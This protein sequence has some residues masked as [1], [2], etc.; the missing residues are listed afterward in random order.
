MT[1]STFKKAV[2]PDRPGCKTLNAI[3]L[4]PCERGVPLYPLRYG[5][6]NQPINA[7][8][9]PTLGVEG[10]PEL[11][12]GKEYGLRVLRPG[13]YVYLFYFRDGRMLTR[14]YQ[15]T[16]DVRF[17]PLWWS[18]ADY[19]D[20]APGRHVPP[21]IAGS[22]LYLLAPETSVAQTVYVLMS[23]TIL[24]HATLWKIEQDTNGL[25]RHLATEVKPEG[26]PEQKNA[27]DAVLLGSSTSELLSPGLS[28]RPRHF[29]WS[30]VV[31][32]E[33]MASTD[34]IFNAM[35][36][37]LLP[38]KDIKPLAVVLNDFL[39]MASELNQICAVDV[40][41]RDR[42]LASNKHRL[43]SAALVTS[44]FKHAEKSYNEGGKKQEIYEALE[45]QRKLVDLSGARGFTAIYEKELKV[46][47]EA[48]NRTGVDAAVWARLMNKSGLVGKA[49][50]L[51]DLSCAHN[52]SDFE[53]A[54][55]NCLAVS[56]Y[57]EAGLAAL[58]EQIEANPE[59][60]PLWRALSAGS[61][62]LMSRLNNPLTIAKRVYDLVD[63]V[64]D[65]RPGTV[66]TDLLTRLLWPTLS[67]APPH[68]SDVYVRRLRHVAEMRFG[69]VLGRRD[70]PLEQYKKWALELQ[71]YTE[72]GDIQKRWNIRLDEGPGPLPD[73]RQHSI[74]QRIEIWEWEKVTPST[75]LG[76]PHAMPTEGNPLLRMW[77]KM[78]EPAGIAF[79][80][81]GAALA[82][83]GLRN[84]IEDLRKDKS[85]INFLA[86]IGWVT[87][88]IGASVEVGLFT[89]SHIAGMKRN[90]AL[91]KELK[92]RGIK[93]GSMMFGAGSAAILSIVDL[94]KAGKAWGEDNPEQA[95]L[96]LGASLSG[97][98]IAYATAASGSL[99]LST[100]K[101][102]GFAPWTL[103][104]IPVVWLL[105]A[106]AAVV[107]TAYL[108][109]LASDAEHGPMEILLK[110]SAWGQST[111][112]F[113]LEN[114]M[115]AWRSV[116]Y[117]PQISA[118]WE[119]VHGSA[120]KLRL[121]CILPLQDHLKTDFRADLNVRLNGKTLSGLRSDEVIAYSG[122]A[123]SLDTHF[124]YSSLT[125]DLGVDRG[126]IITMHEDAQVE[127][128]YLYRPDVKAQPTLFL[129]QPGAPEPLLFK[130]S[131]WFSETIDPAMLAPVRKPL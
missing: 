16:M 84:S 29:P 91:A 43:Q 80:G 109:G 96:Y 7:S 25:R 54:V 82:M 86:T 97:G 127:L 56:T 48:I 65:E 60:S 77:K 39:G 58:T 32:P 78:Q 45:R 102:A 37:A 75:I 76:E 11:K 53:Q 92:I 62:S 20:E 31:L 22:T 61:A 2:Q 68:A 105:V 69:I 27:F 1:R 71:G 10:Y 46:F 124:L 87:A 14:H 88:L 63:K 13:S 101:V 26:G 28:Q 98:L 47:D 131:G 90:A 12:A 113:S 115:S 55:L 38:R 23:D 67:S 112:K 120:G 99:A 42:Y 130:S 94:F 114:E 35:H 104:V 100:I 117:S 79:A 83:W 128:E 81:L 41:K 34:F 85:Y 95:W 8:I 49:L 24:T 73:T 15:V 121:N 70:V 17:A 52:A 93:I 36:R 126:W 72:L 21:D 18:E 6:S 111:P 74:T 59:D 119:Q 40:A 5:V 107:L 66:I 106:V 9:Y 30:E 44:Y 122:N 103:G 125:D 19:N 64:L 108:V 33:R 123:V 50:E 110:H 57:T 118:A 51:F 4:P 129:Q 89:A 3:S 116:Q